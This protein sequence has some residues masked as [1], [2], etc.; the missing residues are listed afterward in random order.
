[1]KAD[2]MNI[3]KFLIDQFKH[4]SRNQ[5]KLIDIKN[6]KDLWFQCLH[7]YSVFYKSP[8]QIMS[9]SFI[10]ER[11][12]PIDA[13]VIGAVCGDVYRACLSKKIILTHNNQ[14]N[15][16]ICHN[17]YNLIAID[18]FGMVSYEDNDGESHTVKILELAQ[19][20][21]S[22]AN[23]SSQDA[24]YIGFLSG[25]ELYK[26]KNTLSNRAVKRAFLRLVE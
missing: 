16:N 8:F 25:I 20:K 19:N 9:N 17:H 12:T 14:L 1:M 18:K 10:I 4:N 3:R 11:I 21:I 5:I 24:Y 13:C 23:F 2:D 6:N 15:N 22:I 26:I 7:S